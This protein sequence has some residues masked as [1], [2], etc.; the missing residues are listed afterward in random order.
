MIESSTNIKFLPMTY[1]YPE[2]FSHMFPSRVSPWCNNWSNVFD[3]T[4]HKKAASG[5]PN[6]T[7]S[8]D[9]DPQFV[10]PLWQGKAIVARV[11]E[12]KGEELRSLE[13]VMPAD[14]D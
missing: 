5:E 9:L 13:E 8:F 12:L 10:R 1:E 4:P 2:L 7:L 6:F 11:R 14:L 3:F